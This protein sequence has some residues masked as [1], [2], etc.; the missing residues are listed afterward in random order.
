[1]ILQICQLSFLFRDSENPLEMADSS[2]KPTVYRDPPILRH[3][4]VFFLCINL[5]ILYQHPNKVPITRERI[6]FFMAHCS[7]IIRRSEGRVLLEEPSRVISSHGFG[8]K[9]SWQ[10]RNAMTLSANCLQDFFRTA[11]MAQLL[12]L[13]ISPLNS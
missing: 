8:V 2:R 11:A 13:R 6:P 9:F 10:C 5:M 4:Y 12:H 1:M 3:T 7:Q